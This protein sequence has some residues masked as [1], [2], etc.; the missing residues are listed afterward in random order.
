MK[1]WRGNNPRKKKCRPKKKMGKTGGR[2]GGNG[3]GIGGRG[4]MVGLLEIVDGVLKGVENQ[5]SPIYS[6]NLQ[7]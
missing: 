1:G 2:G 7:P 3:S 4:E 5:T 6:L